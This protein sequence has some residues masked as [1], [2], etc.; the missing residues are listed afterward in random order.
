MSRALESWNS[1]EAF[2]WKSSKREWLGRR[3][4]VA[5]ALAGDG[6]RAADLAL[7]LPAHERCLRFWIAT[8]S[9]E[10]QAALTTLSNAPVA[11][12]YSVWARESSAWSSNGPVEFSPPVATGGR[13]AFGGAIV[14]ARRRREAARQWRRIRG[15]RSTTP[16]E[17]L[18]ASA[19]SAASGLH[20]DS[21][22]WLRAG[23]P[24]L[25]TVEVTASPRNA[26]EAY[27]PLRWPD[28]VLAAAAESG[29]DPWLLAGIARQ[30]ST[31]SAHAVSPRG[32]VGVVQLLP[33]TA[34]VHARA[35]GL[36]SSPDLHD[37]DLNLRLGARELSVL[38]RKFGAV[39]PALASYN[40]GETRVRT[41]WRRQP[42][43]RR[44]TEE[45]PVPG[46]LQLCPQSGLI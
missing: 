41:W 18:A 39:E 23:F 12:L 26:V 21:I 24:L 30:E 42:D 28:A 5:L 8:T 40:A 17:A 27:L 29:V 38:L 35:L 43:R 33:S 9:S 34:R 7:S 4:G 31:F 16:S 37:P 19:L 32:A 22:R 6:E 1:L 36:G 13:T 11:D 15:L 44:F 10:S 14:R 45:I 25:G 3:L 46:D 2:G 20:M